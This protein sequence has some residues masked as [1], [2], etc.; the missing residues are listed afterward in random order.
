VNYAELADFFYVWLRLGLKD[1]YPWFAP[2]F[3]PKADE[4]V[5]NRVRGKSNKDFFDGLSAVFSKVHATLLEDG[6]M[7]FTFHHTDEEGTVWEGLLQSLCETGFEIV[8]IYPIHAERE[9]SLHLQDKENISYDLIHVCRKRRSDPETRS[10]AGI[11]QEVRKSAR[12]ELS[13]IEAGRYG[14]EPLGPQDVRL[15]CIGKCLELYSNHYGQVV[16]HEG[17]PLHLHEALQDIGTIVDNLVTRERPLPPELEET[18]PVTYAWLRVLVDVKAEININDL[19]KALRAMQVTTD[20]LKNAGLIIKGR[21]GRGRFFKIK[22]PTERLNSLKERISHP[23]PRPPGEGR[24]RDKEPLPVAFDMPLVDLVHLLIAAAWAGESVAPWLER[25]SHL[26]PKVRA[27]LRYVRDRRTDWKEYIDRVLNLIDGA[28]LFDQPSPNP[29]PGGEGRPVHVLRGGEVRPTAS[30]GK[31]EGKSSHPLPG[32][33]GASSHP[34]PGGEGA[35]S[36]PLPPGEGK[37]EGKGR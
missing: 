37:G 24:V 30:F 36:H 33:E 31:A 28:P 3:T 23:G 26:R 29:L 35:S 12:A 17:K 20:D 5:E 25:F 8:A 21:T 2:E 32:G 16:D 4:I 10:W 34:L 14:N 6:L 27:A 15:I 22:Q 9:A 11:R 13:A 1:R 18:D 19:N 7:V